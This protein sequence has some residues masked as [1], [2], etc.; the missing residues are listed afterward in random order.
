[1]RPVLKSASY[2]LVHTP[3][4]IVH[5]GTTVLTEKV[6]SPDSEF[7]KTVE[8]KIRSYEDVINYAPN[9][10]YIG[11]MKPEALRDLAEPWCNTPV[12]GT[13]EGK[14]GS[15][16][17]QDEFIAMIKVSDAGRLAG[18]SKRL[19]GQSDYPSILQLWD[20]YLE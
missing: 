11:N 12:E 2:I 19:K 6:T 18:Y 8:S 16:V 15:I 9:Q 3:D 13:R 10:V 20:L 4:M 1:M 5:N 14:Y 7:L 17:P